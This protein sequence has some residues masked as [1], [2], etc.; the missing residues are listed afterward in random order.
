LHQIVD[1][2]MKTN[3]AYPQMTDL[4]WNH[5]KNASK[6]IKL[7]L[8]AKLSES[9]IHEDGEAKETE[10]SASNFYGVWKDTEFEEDADSLAEHIH[11]SRS[12]NNNIEAF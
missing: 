4:Y 6:E 12:F 8:I 3:T 5:I 7:A 11:K 1:N 10:I 9:L 2:Y